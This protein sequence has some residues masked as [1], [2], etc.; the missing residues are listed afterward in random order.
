MAVGYRDAGRR[1]KVFKRSRAR[2]KRLAVS[3]FRANGWKIPEPP[4]VTF[5]AF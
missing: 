1:S 3:V 4:G 2:A 5:L